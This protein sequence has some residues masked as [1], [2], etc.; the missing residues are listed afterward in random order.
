MQRRSA[1]SLIA[2]SA[3]AT[4]A[5]AQ[6]PQKTR[7]PC[8]QFVY[9]SFD[10]GHMGIA[11]FVAQVLKRQQV[12][13]S[14]F[15]ANERTLQG[16][17]CLGE[18]W[19]PWWRER[20]GEG[21]VLASHTWQHAL[22]RGDLPPDGGERRFHIEPTAGPDAGQRQIWTASQYCADIRRAADR[23]AEITGR[24]TPPIFRAPGQRNSRVLL[25]HAER[26]GWRHIGWAETGF[27]GDEL[28]S[29]KYPNQ[30]LLA[31]ALKDIAPG[32]ILL[33][34]LGASSRQDPWAPA[35]LEPLIKGLKE[36]GLCFRTLRDHPR[37][38]PLLMPQANAA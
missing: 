15:A 31:Q 29:D 21:H 9:L 3:C 33:A 26:C 13:A 18:H 22:W 32:D 24:P 6:K 11:P 20:A 25:S 8:E 17:G 37:I 12:L 1:L 27:L 5:F 10:T 14:F 19:A 2:A 28:P 7:K 16:D 30:A 34:H 23:L 4:S 36:R 35:V 38:S